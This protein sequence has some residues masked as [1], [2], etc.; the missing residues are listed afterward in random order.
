MAI[1][2]KIL[3]IKDGKFYYTKIDSIDIRETNIPN[4]INFSYGREIFWEVELFNFNKDT[5]EVSVRVLDYFPENI[6]NFFKQKQKREVKSF[7]FEK[8][9]W[10]KI[11]H[12]LSSYPRGQ[13]SDIMVGLPNIENRNKELS[14]IE[15]RFNKSNF[16]LK[17]I[18]DFI[19]NQGV[20]INEK[21]SI[22]YKN[23]VFKDGLVS[24]NFK[25][26]L[27][28]KKEEIKILNSKILCEYDYIKNYFPKYFKKGKKFI[29]QLNGEVQLGKLIKYEA[30]SKEIE[31]INENVISTVRNIIDVELFDTVETGNI[32]KSIL[33]VENLIDV[34]NFDPNIKKCFVRDP[35][36]LLNSIIKI[37]DVKN[38]KQLEYLAGLKQDENY[39]LRFTLKPLFGFLFYVEGHNGNHF[40][41]ELLNSHA[42]YIWSFD[43]KYAFFEILNEI[44][45]I[46]NYIRIN[47][48]KK[49]KELVK[50]ESENKF[51]FSTL[52]HKKKLT[53]NKDGFVEWKNDLE[54]IIKK[55]CQ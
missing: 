39:Q 50:I 22:Y 48:R 29:V 21:F 24:V 5:K 14:E 46:I 4:G 8:F 36:N 17:E 30:S 12:Q 32:G 7:R 52:Y 49:Y 1:P 20:T 45:N 53:K 13:L 55:Q 33:S 23:A 3:R 54:K 44:D 18:D 42:T 38:K 37:K 28:S 10:S 25:P 9:E 26:K 43:S 47:G 16:N 27:C 2:T 41:W 34:S 15:E 40:C 11:E 35:Q 6:L 51:L 19:E 31:I